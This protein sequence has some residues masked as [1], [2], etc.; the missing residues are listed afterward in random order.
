MTLQLKMKLFLALNI[1]MVMGGGDDQIWWRGV[2]R[3]GGGAGAGGGEGG[4]DQIFE[5]CCSEAYSNEHTK[6]T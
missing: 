1:K 3:G 2:L 6:F 5:T 4:Y